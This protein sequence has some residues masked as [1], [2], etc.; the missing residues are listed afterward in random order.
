MDDDF[1]GIA[2]D[3]RKPPNFVF[4]DILFHENND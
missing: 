2:H 1:F 4:N 3:I